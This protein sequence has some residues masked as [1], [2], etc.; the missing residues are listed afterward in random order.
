MGTFAS[1]EEAREHFKNDRFATNTGIRIDD[2]GEDNATCSLILTDD[3]KNAYGG[4]MGGVIF[5][6]ADLAFAVCANNIH[7]L[8]VAQNVSINYLAAPKGDKL[9]AKAKCLKSG[10]TTSV[11]NV[12][13]SDETGDVALFTGTAFKL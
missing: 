1:I 3:H 11:I 4:V 2:M 5:T 12:M 9:T 8:S 7:S 6:L 10:R 13:I